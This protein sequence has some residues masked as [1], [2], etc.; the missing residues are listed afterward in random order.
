M[1]VIQLVTQS[2][3]GPVDHA[4]DVACELARR[5][6]DSHL[7]GPPL[8][9]ETRLTRTGVHRHH[10]TM[11]TKFDVHGALSIATDLA[12]LRPDVLHCQDRRAGLVGRLVGRVIGTPRVV[13]TVHGVP[14]GL[15]DR[16]AGNALA[17]PR[18]RR[19]RLYY[20]TGERL[21]GRALPAQ[22]VVPCAAVADYLAGE[23]GFDRRQ[24]R[25]VPNGVDE[26]RFA[27]G[28]AQRAAG[29]GT[30]AGRHRPVTAL[31]LGAMER[32]KRVDWLIRLT[33]AIPGLS[34]LLAGDGPEQPRARLMAAD[35]GV[36][37]RVC[38]LGFVADPAEA[39]AAADLF[40]LPSAAEACPLSLLQA[41]AA[42]LPVVATRVGGVPELVRQGVD[43]LLT[44][45]DDPAALYAATASLA[46]DGALRAAMGR[47]ARARAVETFSLSSC[48][49]RLLDVYTGAPA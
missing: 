44:P 48:V 19:D 28:A 46:A 26:G 49:D 32:V 27:P 4:V 13:Y 16:V 21:L 47:S 43:G 1:R 40:V 36:A 30:G 14:D 45:S 17:A 34:V 15:S 12:A 25:V 9:E 35:L 42:G 6:H 37:D 5:G 7:I 33:A 2:G 41:M 29:Q 18:R 10:I 11:R 31:W 23:V 20:V 38:F 39:F 22:L 24:V 8:R 3:G